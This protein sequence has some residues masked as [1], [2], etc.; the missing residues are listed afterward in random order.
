MQTYSSSNKT[1]FYRVLTQ[2]LNKLSKVKL[3]EYIVQEEKE[4]IKT[5]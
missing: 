3:K 5:Y 2:E 4:E 1:N